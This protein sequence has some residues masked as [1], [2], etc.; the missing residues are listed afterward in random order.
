MSATSICLSLDDTVLPSIGLHDAGSPQRPDIQTF[1]IERFKKVYDA[2]V[3]QLLPM[4]MTSWNKEGIEGVLGLRPGLCEKFFVESYLDRS[5]EAIVAD[6][7]GQPVS[8]S[9]IIETGNLAGSR[10]SS[11]LMFIVLTQVLYRSGFHWATFTATAQVNSL[12]HRLG[13]NPQIVCEADPTRLEDKGQSWGSYYANR[14]CVIIG[15]VRQ[16]YATLRKNEYAQYVLS[17]HQAEVNLIVDQLS[18]FCEGPFN[19]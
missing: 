15:D 2:K 17:R 9:R 4:L 7:N 13:F 1:V 6:F 3:T 5:I 10:G 11:Q 14:P 12:L 19:E 18:M 8:R 16:G